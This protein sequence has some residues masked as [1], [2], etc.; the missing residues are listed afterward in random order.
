VASDW[1]TFVD[2]VVADLTGSVSGLADPALIV[3]RYAPYDPGDL[4]AEAGERHLS[5]FP[6]ADIAQ[7]ATPFTTAPGGDL[8]TETYRV[9]YWESAG[10]ESTRAISDEDAAFALFELA[11]ATRERFYVIA[12]LMLGG[13]T[14]VRYLG[15]AFP[16][17]SSSVRWFAL[18][19]RA[20]RVKQAT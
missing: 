5:V 7:E 9:V 2:A 13:T 20:T 8:L 12:N 11:S 4:Q 3:H 10:D 17:R 19:V 16:E 6:V 14:Q 1:T 15:M 18:G